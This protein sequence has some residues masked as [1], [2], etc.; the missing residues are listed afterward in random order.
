MNREQKRLALSCLRIASAGRGNRKC[1]GSRCVNT[2]RS[3]GKDR[4]PTSL[5]LF[6]S[7]PLFLDR[8]CRRVSVF[9]FESVFDYENVHLTMISNFD[10][11]LSDSNARKLLKV[12]SSLFF[13]LSS[14]F[15]HLNTSSSSIQ[16]PLLNQ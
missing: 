9:F 16:S 4:M 11:L 5:S 10:N 13:Y 6:L 7:T 8:V 3:A 14:M 2:T 12:V 1:D 15:K